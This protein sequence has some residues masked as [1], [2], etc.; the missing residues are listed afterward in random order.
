MGAAKLRVKFFGYIMPIKITE[1]ISAEDRKGNELDWLC[2]ESWRLPDQLNMLEEWLAKNKS[3]PKGFYAADIAFSPREDAFGGGGVI[4]LRSMS[5][6]V[7]I[8]MQ[9][10]L[11]EYPEGSD[12]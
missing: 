12:E 6:M 1:Y 11:S 10:Y 9:L 8:G 7:A 5:I 4:S 3:R 2:D